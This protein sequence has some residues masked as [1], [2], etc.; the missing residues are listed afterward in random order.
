MK[1][2]FV[3]LFLFVFPVVAVQAKEYKISSAA[4]LSSLHLTA[5]DKVI[6]KDGIWKDQ[7]LLFS[8]TGTQKDP[9]VYNG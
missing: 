2:D 3:V 1:K 7:Q 6:L 4:E 8:G 9:V 5:G